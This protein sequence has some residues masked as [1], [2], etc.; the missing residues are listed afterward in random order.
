M[1]RWTVFR[2]LLPARRWHHLKRIMTELHRE[3]LDWSSF[4]DAV[5]GRMTG[6]ARVSGTESFHQMAFSTRLLQSSFGRSRRKPQERHFA[7]V[8]TYLAR[9]RRNQQLHAVT[10]SCPSS[11]QHWRENAPVGRPILYEQFN[12][13]YVTNCALTQCQLTVWQQQ[14]VKV[15]LL[16]IVWMGACVRVRYCSS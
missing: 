7:K 11:G 9:A 15:D 10:S 4:V 16:W 1:P 2:D 12:A 8:A 3:W 14:F 5:N 13:S 6:L